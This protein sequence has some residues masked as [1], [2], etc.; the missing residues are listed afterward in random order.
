MH[1]PWE[2]EWAIE[3]AGL[4][5][6]NF[7]RWT[8]QALLATNA[9]PVELARQLF[10]APFILVSHGTEGDP[11]LNYGNR[12][13]LRLWDMTWEELTRTPSRHTAEAPD[14]EERA[15]LLAQVTQH[16]FIDNYSGIRVS[17]TGRRFRIARAVVWNLFAEDAAYAG[18]AAT[19]NEWEFL[20]GCAPTREILAE[21]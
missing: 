12:A 14:R 13:A 20:D 5:A 2:T 8:G 1:A 16:G 15:R 7:R 10:E 9:E 21:P 17:K 3:R 4:L 6:R 18:Q 19:F 11:I